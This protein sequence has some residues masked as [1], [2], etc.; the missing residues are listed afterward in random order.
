MWLI[1]ILCLHTEYG[2]AS[3]KLSSPMVVVQDAQSGAILY[4][5]SPDVL[6]PIASL[7]KLMTAM[8]FLDNASS[9]LDQQVMITDDDVDTVK[10]STSH[11]PVGSIWTARE[12]LHIALMASDNRA[13]HALGRMYPG[14]YEQFIVDM[15]KKA[16]ELKLQHTH[17]DD[18]SGLSP[19]NV[20]T[21]FELAYI[22][23]HAA[24][25]PLIRQFSTDTDESFVNDGKTLHFKNTNEVVR[26]T[27]WPNLML[28]K[29]GYTIEAGRCVTMMGTVNNHAVTMVL[30][31]G[32]S[33]ALRTKDAMA[34]QQW[35]RSINWSKRKSY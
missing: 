1:F 28:S 14:G 8:V 3:L 7:S 25:Y 27:K 9:L 29:T 18:N 20:S 2:H 19:N 10:K 16:K 22:T 4:S 33:S 24:Q 31:A 15:N 30:L 32:R 6:V 26:N 12:L 13:A 34:I 17:F 35:L 5:K 21:P 23:S 11:L